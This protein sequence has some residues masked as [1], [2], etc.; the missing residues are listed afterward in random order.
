MSWPTNR[1]LSGWSST[2]VVSWPTTEL[3]PPSGQDRIDAELLN[4]DSN[5]LQT[6]RLSLGELKP[7]KVD[8]RPSLP[9]GQRRVVAGERRWVILTRRQ[10]ATP[11]AQLLESIP[12]D[13]GRG[14]I[15][16]VARRMCHDGPGVRA[17]APSQVRHVG[18]DSAESAA[19]RMP[20]PNRLGDPIS[21]HHFAAVDDQ[22]RQQCL[23]TSP[24]DAG[25]DAA[26][27]DA[28]GPEDLEVHAR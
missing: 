11:L 10:H 18:L 5:L 7:G 24:S 12:V 17:E 21:R 6:I 3:C 9:Q 25:V 20:G 26:A 4:G 14:D 19:R 2:S 28:H 13:G 1:S 23:A 22:Q 15:E 8:E 27:H 16:H